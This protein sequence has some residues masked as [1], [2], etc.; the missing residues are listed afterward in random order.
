[1]A[2]DIRADIYTLGCVLYQVLSG[3][4]PFTGE[5]D[6]DILLQHFTAPPEPIRDPSVRAGLQTVIG[7][8][9]AKD[10]KERYATPEKAAQALQ[11]FLAAPDQQVEQA[12]SL[13][14][15]YLE[16]VDTQPLEEVGNAPIAAERW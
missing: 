8:M 5:R 11:P 13:T 3:Q 4:P 14:K 6:F 7:T 10:P 15:S 9:L 2:A 1:H 16:W 12:S